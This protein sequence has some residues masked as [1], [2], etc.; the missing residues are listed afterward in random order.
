MIKFPLTIALI[1][2]AIA[3][4]AVAKDKTTFTHDGVTYTYTTE[5]VG[6][7]TVI[8]GRA[9][10]GDDF[11][12]VVDSKGRIAGKANEAPVSFTV[13]DAVAA[14]NNASEVASR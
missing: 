14:V 13:A 6:N 9:M 3:A 4:P 2:T 1:A 12:Y 11:Y 10:P 5:K 7:S 8:Q